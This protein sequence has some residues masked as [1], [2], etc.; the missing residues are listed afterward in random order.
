MNVN[1]TY[2]SYITVTYNIKL[3]FKS[4]IKKIFVKA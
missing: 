3:T 1:V 2:D 4:K